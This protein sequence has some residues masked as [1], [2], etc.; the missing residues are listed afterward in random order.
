MKITIQGQDYTA[1]L[2]AA[3]PLTIERKLNEPSICQLWLSLPA[4]GSLA[5]PARYPVHRGDR[6]RRHDLLHGLHCG[7]SAAGIRR[8]GPRRPALPDRD[9][10]GERRVAA[11]PVADAAQ[12]GHDGG[13]RRSVARLACDSYRIDGALHAG[14]LAKHAGGQLRSRAGR[15]LEQERRASG[16]PWRGPHIAR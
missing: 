10:G 11:R 14:A 6:R 1:A 16:Q 13:E 2:D 9:P 8:A 12:R 5:A 15:E 7:K 4:N 3:R